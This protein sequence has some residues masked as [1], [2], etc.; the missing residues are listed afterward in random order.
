[1]ANIQ[2]EIL[3]EFYRKLAKADGFTEAKVKQVR[4]LFSGSKKP[5]AP[6]LVKVFSENSKD[7]LS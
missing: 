2:E 3:E 1:M 4:N 5:K 7:S 6:D